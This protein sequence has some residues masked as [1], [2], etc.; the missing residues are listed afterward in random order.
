MKMYKQYTAKIRNKDFSAYR[1]EYVTHCSIN[2]S[3]PFNYGIINSFYLQY[4]HSFRVGASCCRQKTKLLNVIGMNP[5][6]KPILAWS[7][8]H[9]HQSLFDFKGTIAGFAEANSDSDIR[10]PPSKRIY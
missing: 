6:Y 5:P 4:R 8:A 10:K 9:Q 7:T 2:C 1:N 3:H